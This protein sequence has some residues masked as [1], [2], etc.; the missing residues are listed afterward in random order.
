MTGAL[1]PFPT[2]R[3]AVRRALD[4]GLERALQVGARLRGLGLVRDPLRW[5]G[6]GGV[7]ESIALCEKAN[8]DFRA[9]V[10]PDPAPEITGFRSSRVT[11]RRGGGTVEWIEF[12]SPRP[13]G[14]PENDRVQL[15]ILRPPGLATGDSSP[16]VLFH[17]A[18]Y[19]TRWHPWD[20]L[21]D[22]LTRR[23]PVAMMAAPYHY[24]RIPAGQAPGAASF[25]SNPYCLFLAIRQWF[26]DECAA[27]R[28]LEE[29]CRLRPVASAG[30]S[31]GAY[32]TL[33]SGAFGFH[34]LPVV[35]IAS[36]NRYTHALLH[37]SIGKDL[38][39]GMAR[40]GIGPDLLAQAVRSFELERWVSPL[41]ERPILYVDGLW[42]RVDPP[43]SLDRLLDALRPSR[44]LRL[45]AGHATLLFH[46]RAIG[47]AIVEF[48]EETGCLG[49]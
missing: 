36:T 33:L 41:R 31:L 46:R 14:S 25:N 6:P 47:K 3:Y 2:A 9:F 19:Q 29:R 7:E 1:P 16:V 22:E 38:L 10:H 39:R 42:D 43:P 18:V 5:F 34:S 48:L 44:T 49:G 26:A 11:G 28:L 24:A 40:V 8:L 17:H 23:V 35:S 30:Y 12:D 15:R 21:L 27:H 20:W 13:S 45:P 4:E 32:Q 37:G